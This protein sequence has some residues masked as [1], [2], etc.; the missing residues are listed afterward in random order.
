V[1]FP[2]LSL[3]GYDLAAPRWGAGDARLDTIAAACARTGAT[4]VVGAPYE[5]RLA[6]LAIDGSGVV[7]VYAKHHLHGAEHD[8]FAAGDRHVVLDVGGRRVGQGICFDTAHADH[9]AAARAQG[10][11]LYAAGALFVEGEE[12]KLEE[13]FPALASDTGLWV[14]MANWSGPTP[15]GRACERSGAWAPDGRRVAAPNGPGPQLVRAALSA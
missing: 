4:A 14:A 5:G 12:D 15:I 9:A 13:R 10:A 11:E 6:A 7:A 2:E 8:L 1:L 3:T